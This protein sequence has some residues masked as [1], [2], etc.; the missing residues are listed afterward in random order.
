[1]LFYQNRINIFVRGWSTLKKTEIALAITVLL[2]AAFI[3]IT[4]FVGW[5][6]FISSLSGHNAQLLAPNATLWEKAE[7][8]RYHGDVCQC[9]PAFDLV[10]P[11]LLFPSTN[12]SI[13]KISFN[14]SLI[15]GM[16]PVDMKNATFTLSTRHAE[17]TVRYDNPAVNLTRWAYDGAMMNKQ[18]FSENRSPEYNGD[19]VFIELDLDKMGFSSP[20]LGP[21]ERFSLVITPQTGYRIAI[22]RMTPAEF[23]A[24]NLI[25]IPGWH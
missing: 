14:V 12:S 6:T 2:L 15:P 22:T 16:M 13:T 25:E 18:E 7:W 24:G 23:S 3:I 21:D 19:P 9:L 5:G 8:E 10:G 1:L 4:F 17:K 20:A 11:I